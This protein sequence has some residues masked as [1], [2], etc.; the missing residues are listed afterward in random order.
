MT[1]AAPS[2]F[3]ELRTIRPPIGLREQLSAI[4]QRRD[5]IA[6]LTKRE[7]KA[8]HKNSVIGFAWNL[9][10]PLLQMM[11]YTVVFTYF[12]PGRIPYFPLK[13]LSGMAIFAL[14]TASL[15]GAAVSV[16]G[17][18][19]LV[20]KI[21]FP[22]EIL[23]IASV[24]SNLVTFLSRVAIVIVGLL[25]YWR[26]PQWNML[27]LAVYASVVTLI[28]ATG[29]GLLLATA[30]VFFRDTQHFL[31]LALMALFWFTPVVWNYDYLAAAVVNRW[32]PNAE[33]ALLANPMIATVTAFERVFYNP[34]SLPDDTR[35]NFEMMLRPASWYAT[36]LTI[37]L[38][39]SLLV[40]LVGL[41]VF[42]R[43]EGDF[44]E[45]L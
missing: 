26:A 24:G 38:I 42:R 35:R 17:N 43:H 8:R 21:W 23:P 27:W 37:A 34:A 32:G 29:F 10:N 5:L 7:V 44:A 31:E 12:M 20:L 41:R 39:I 19:A 9:L 45:L 11:V 18:S 40:L 28:L 3:D 33:W 13:L 16:S 30:N 2:R 6:N 15:N 4:W 22:R 36:N 25:A 1:T 14:F